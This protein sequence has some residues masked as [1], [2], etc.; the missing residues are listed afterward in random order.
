[1]VVRF[2]D[3]GNRI[4][5]SASK[6]TRGRVFRSPGNV[7]PRETIPAAASVAFAPSFMPQAK[8]EPPARSEP[9]LDFVRE[10]PCMEC[11]APGPSDPHHYGPR[12]MGQKADDYRTV[13][14]CRRDH[15]FFHDH[16]RLRSD[17]DS[18]QTH[19]R[20]IERQL[21]LVIEFMR[22]CVKR[23]P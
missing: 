13:P 17:V 3:T 22:R 18:V 4:E 19:V 11:H 2:D 9:Y 10:H 8:P 15:D 12:G 14:L 6:V 20:F 21:Q 23:K 7:E 16:G 1:M 5:V